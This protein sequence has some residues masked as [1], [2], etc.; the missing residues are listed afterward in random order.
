MIA[1]RNK[2]VAYT[3]LPSFDTANGS[4]S[5]KSV[6]F[7]KFCYHGYVVRQITICKVNTVLNQWKT[8]AR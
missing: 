4:L 7:Q 1:L 5:Q 2:T 8:D 6:Q 3:F